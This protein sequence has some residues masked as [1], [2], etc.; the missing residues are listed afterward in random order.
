M[1][2]VKQNGNALGLASEELRCDRGVVI[3]AVTDKGAALQLVPEELRGWRNTV[4]IVVFE[5]SNSMKPYPPV[6]YAYTGNF[7]SVV[8]VFVPQ[9]FDEVSNRIPPTSQEL[10]CDRDVVM[11]AVTQS[12]A[13][14]QFGSAELRSPME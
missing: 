1:Q 7:N 12:G 10:K 6:V 9:Q 13:A 11:A 4:K 3:G 2:A 14:L 8:C 5:I